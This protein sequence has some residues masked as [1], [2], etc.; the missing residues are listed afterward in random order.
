MELHI[1]LEDIAVAKSAISY[2]NG[3]K[4]ELIYRGWWAGELALEKSYEEVVHLI[5]IGT[6][7]NAQELTQFRNQL[8]ALRNI[9][10]STK[11]L[12][13][14]LPREATDMAAL[15]S[16]ISSM[17]LA[18]ESWPPTNDQALAIFAKAPTIIA[19]RYRWLNNL[20]PVEPKAGLFHIENYLY[21]LTGEVPDS[22]YAKAL[23]AYLILCIDNIPLM[24]DIFL[25]HRSRLHYAHSCPTPIA[26]FGR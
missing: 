10:Q 13:E 18:G 6:L 2:A 23:A 11:T 26:H 16:V 1:G 22:D 14:S 5:M 17:S 21:M 12:I 25:T 20:K 7:P 9:D 8:I 19:Y 24:N 3:E 15:R 4:G